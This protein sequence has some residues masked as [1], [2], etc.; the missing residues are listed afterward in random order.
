MNKIWIYMICIGIINSF[1]FSR[2][3]ELNKVIITESAK[4]VDF[5]ISLIGIMALW[6]GIMNIA[7]ES[8]LVD[9]IGKWLEPVIKFLF[10][11]IVKSK[12]A[13]SYILMNMSLNMLGASNGAT[14]FGLKAMEKM[15]QINPNKTSASSDMIMFL[16]INMSSIQLV[17]ITVLKIRLD[18]GSVNPSEIIFTTLFATAISTLVGIV[19]C[20]LMERSS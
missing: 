14:A 13:V 20:K 3:Q 6:M 2:L 15:Q 5:T 16:V 18:E 7:K 12:E 8:G 10:P 4:G 9:L 11:N 19:S 1:I 17:P